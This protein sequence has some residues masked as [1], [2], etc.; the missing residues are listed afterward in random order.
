MDRRD[1]LR[2]T[3]M[4]AATAALTMRATPEMPIEKPNV[5]LIIARQRTIGLSKDTGFPFDARRTLDRLQSSG[6]GFECNYCT[7]PVCVA[8]RTSMLT[9]RWPKAHGFRTN[10]HANDAFF[11]K[12]SHQVAKSRGYR[13]QCQISDELVRGAQL[14]HPIGMVSRQ[15]PS[16]SS[17][18]LKN[19]FCEL[20]PDVPFAPRT[21]SGVSGGIIVAVGTM[22]STPTV[23]SNSLQVVCGA[24]VRRFRMRTRL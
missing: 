18:L 20:L 16:F 19:G 21:V 9:G 4:S 23:H 8:S 7:A 22:F 11:E 17:R 15:R 1:F 3:A 14:V 6:V 13:A 5:I 10:L 2:L 12:D 24:S